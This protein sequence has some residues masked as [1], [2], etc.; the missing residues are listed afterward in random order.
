M[1][2]VFIY[3]IPAVGKL[4]V[5]KE[6]A[7]ITDYK[8]FHNHLTVDLLTSVLEF[9]TKE[10]LKLNDKI[11]LEILQLAAHKKINLI[12]TFCYSYPED[13]NFIRKV[14]KTIEKEGGQVCFVNLE[15]NKE[16]L[17]KRVKNPSRSKYK[18]IKKIKTLEQ[19]LKKYEFREIPFVKQLLINNT[20]ISAK[21]VAEM[22]KTH[23]KL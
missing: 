1:K 23:Y 3:G 18:K 15:C 21:K 13:N 4:T 16:E 10:Y 14:I 11:R 9:G 20:N 7:K 19:T 22:I 2:L 12:A 17:K 8:I 6:L 5:A